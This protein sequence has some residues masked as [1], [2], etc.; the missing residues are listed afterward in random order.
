MINKNNKIKPYIMLLPVLVFIVGIFI[1][2]IVFGLF[3]S[4]GYFPAIGLKTFT[5]KYYINII[6]NEN[7]LSSL[8]FSIYTSFVSSFL[9]VILGLMLSYVLI[10]GKNNR[11]GE[12]INI[13]KLPIMVP[14]TIAALLI[15]MLFT[16]SGL[17][18]RVFYSLGIISEMSMFPP[19]VF[20]NRG[21]G[22]ILAYLWKGLPFI[23]LVTYDVLKNVNNKYSKIAVNLGASK[24]QIF[25]HVLLPLTMPTIASGFIII[26]AF[27]FGAFE[28]P[29]LLGPSTPKS[30]PVLSYIYYNS[31]NL[32]DRPNA[33]VINMYI[34]LCSFILV[35][36]YLWA[37][38][39][40]KRYNS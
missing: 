39:F 17:I 32:A 15:F 14:H 37:F 2:G 38:Q 33:M 6:T 16:Q 10:F 1:T 23:T 25:W 8:K 9:S 29:Y 19:L 28:I 34:T 11:R 20:D 27:S 4:F 24:F 5:I 22:I 26:F 12:L 7:F 35:G 21:F 36:I 18:A 40:I 30:L 13:Y 31:V 3:Q